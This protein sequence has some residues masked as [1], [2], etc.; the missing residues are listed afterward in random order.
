MSKSNITLSLDDLAIDAGKAYAAKSG[1]TLN[2]LVN[3]LLLTLSLSER[4]KPPVLDTT[5]ILQR[6]SAG[7]ASL[8]ETAH[9]LGVQDIGHVLAM[10]REANLPLPLMDESAARLQAAQALPMLKRARRENQPQRARER[11]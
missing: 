9:D 1:L 8:S 11:G 10:M 7:S 3:Q 2:R 5:R 4:M 6:C